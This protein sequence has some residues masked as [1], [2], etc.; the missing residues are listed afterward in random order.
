MREGAKVKVV[1]QLQELGEL[2]GV[3]EFV[4][5]VVDARS[6]SFGVRIRLQNPELKTIAG[7]R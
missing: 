4:D 3:V 6:G 5:R 1:P 7:M 2:E